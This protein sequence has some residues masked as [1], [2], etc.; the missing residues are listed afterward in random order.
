MLLVLRQLYAVLNGLKSILVLDKNNFTIYCDSL[1]VLQALE[2]FNPTHPL[3]QEIFEWLILTKRRGHCIQFCWVPAHVGVQ[4]NERAD[5]LAKAAV[6]RSPTRYPIP[7]RDFHTII[8]NALRRS[9][10]QK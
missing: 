5:Q 8:K 10:Q 1:S 2:A 4:G 6:S 7:F 9:W 3:V